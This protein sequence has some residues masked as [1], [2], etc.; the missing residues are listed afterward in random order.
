[1][2]ETKTEPKLFERKL[3]RATG[4]QK[5]TVERKAVALLWTPDETAQYLG[6]TVGTLQVWRTTKRY[7]LPYLK[8]G[9]KVMYDPDAAIAFKESRTVTPVEA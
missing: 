5:V 8:I 4:N 7:P 2:N 1:M 9:R 3:S 6:V